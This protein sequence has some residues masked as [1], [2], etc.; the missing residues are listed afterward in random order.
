MSSG[1]VNPLWT[2]FGNNRTGPGI[3]K[4]EHYFAVY[5]R[6]FAKFIDT[7]VTVLEIGIYSGGSLGM[8]RSYFGDQCH[9]IGIDIKDACRVYESDFT[10]IYIGDQADRGFWKTLRSQIKEVDIVIDDGGHTPQQQRVTLEEV[11]PWLNS[12]GVYVCEDI[13]GIDNPFAFYASRLAEHLNFQRKASGPILECKAS[14][15][16][17]AIQSVSF[18]PFCLVI[19]KTEQEVRRYAAPKHGTEWQPFFEKTC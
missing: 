19:E 11:L 8:W 10:S 4:W 13:H 6:H 16:Q 3:W 15:F 7:P 14:D 2:Y 18:Y 9:V 12:G 5:H 1:R 17:S